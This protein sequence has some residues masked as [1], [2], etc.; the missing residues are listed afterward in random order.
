MYKKRVSESG[1]LFINFS[2]N[3]INSIKFKKTLIQFELD[4]TF[5]ERAEFNIF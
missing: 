4:K 2:I 3:S 5:L 1:T